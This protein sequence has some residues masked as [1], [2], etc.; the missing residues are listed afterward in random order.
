MASCKEC[1]F[2][3]ERLSEFIASYEDST[4]ENETPKEHFCQIFTD[5]I[6]EKIWEDKKECDRKVRKD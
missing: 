2:Y 5:G 6:P 4:P 3:D 1:I